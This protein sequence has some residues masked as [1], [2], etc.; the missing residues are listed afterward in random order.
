[1]LKDDRR[2]PNP[3]RES[4]QCDPLK[5]KENKQNML[6]NLYSLLIG[7]LE[8]EDL[9]KHLTSTYF[10]YCLDKVYVWLRYRPRSSE[11]CMF[12]SC[13]FSLF[14]IFVV[15]F[16]TGLRRNQLKPLLDTFVV[17]VSKQRKIRGWLTWSL[18]VL[19]TTSQFESFHSFLQASQIPQ[20]VARIFIP[21]ISAKHWTYFDTTTTSSALLQRD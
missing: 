18:T 16:S 10:A 9:L 21:M 3:T 17:P 7:L 4:F 1:M 11:I 6:K 8:P 15:L 14:F 12:F 13:S 5:R 2:G 19:S 20:E